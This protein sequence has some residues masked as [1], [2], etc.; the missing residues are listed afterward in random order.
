MVHGFDKLQIERIKKA[1]LKKPFAIYFV[2]IFLFY[3]FLNILLNELDLTVPTIITS[4]NWLF[5]IPY[6]AFNFLIVP[7]LVA[8]TINLSI[9]R[10]REIKLM[11][12]AKEV[13]KN[14]GKTNILGGLGIFGGILGGACPACIAGFLPAFLGIFGIA[15]FSLNA[16]P[17][18]G[19]EI[20]M[21]STGLLI[22]AIALLSKE[23]S[24]KI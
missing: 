8:L 4:K 18:K 24:C 6:L 22:W 21:L 20:Q 19:L 3:I 14:S 7:F 13:N 11:N 1:V 15:G 16:L 12:N 17:L 2:F 10:F 9:M 5:V 23:P